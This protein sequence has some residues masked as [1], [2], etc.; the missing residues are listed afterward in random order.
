VKALLPRHRIFR[1][2]GLTP[3]AQPEQPCGAVFLTVASIRRDV[4][5]RAVTEVRK[6]NK[7][8]LDYTKH[9]RRMM[10]SI[11]MNYVHDPLSRKAATGLAYAT[12]SD[13]QTGK[14]WT[15]QG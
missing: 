3:R 1:R 12:Q 14:V 6:K 7:C 9:R 4:R 2:P 10:L 8:S 5:A 11:F 13:A 15:P